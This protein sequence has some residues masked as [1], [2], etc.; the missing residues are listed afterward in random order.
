MAKYK[1]KSGGVCKLLSC[2]KI[3]HAQGYCKKHYEK[4]TIVGSIGARLVRFRYR[5]KNKLR[6]NISKAILRSLKGGKKG[7]DW[8]ILVGYGKYD[9]IAHLE[10]QFTEGMSW[11][12]YGKW[13]V[14]HIIPQSRFNFNSYND[15]DF[16]RCW[17]LSNLQPLWA[18][19]NTNKSDLIDKPFQPSLAISAVSS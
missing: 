2:S 12:N 1:V 16:K 6:R 5:R 14:D 17:S 3:H 10:A 13:H 4:F 7:N 11:G 8:E 19:D 15:I 9:L 18:I